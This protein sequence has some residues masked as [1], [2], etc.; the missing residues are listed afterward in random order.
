MKSFIINTGF[1]AALSLSVYAKATDTTATHSP[2]LESDTALQKLIDSARV[3]GLSLA[4]IKDGKI[5]GLKTLGVKNFQTKEKV[6]ATT[7]FEAAS[8]SK[9]VLAYITLKMI[10]RGQL[11]LGTKL[12]KILPHPRLVDTEKYQQITPLLIL[13]HQTGLPN[14]GDDP[15][16]FNFSPGEGFSYSGEGY[17]YL[18]KVLEH[19]S[20]KDLQA[21][22][23]EEVFVPLGMKNSHFTWPEE[24]ALDL[25]TGHDRTQNPVFRSVPEANGASSLHTTA[26]DYAKFMLAWFD[27]KNMP[28]PEQAFP[29]TWLVQMKGDEQGADTPLPEDGLVGWALG[30]GIQSSFQQYQQ[31]YTAWHW[32]DNGVFRA[33]VAINTH[34]Q[35]GIVYFTNSENGLAIAKRVVEPVVGNMNSTFHWLQYAQSDSQGWQQM[36]AGHEAQAKGDLATAIKYFAQVTQ[37]FPQNRR[38][39]NRIAWL[40]QS[41]ESKSKTIHLSSKEQMAITGQYGPRHI[42]LI[43]NNLYYQRQGNAKHQMHP[44]TPDLFAIGDIFDFR[45]EVIKD[46]QDKPIKLV[47]H[48]VNGFQDESPRTH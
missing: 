19:I 24:Q 36:Q 25:A 41:L 11:S 20:G 31:D 23:Q 28:T 18:Q 34:T 5:S 42:S 7:V 44:L 14:W 26:E 38:V 22:A 21:L 48:Y 43:D 13:S 17:V 1:W 47:G 33:F 9:P 27:R 37:Q 39:K 6:T 15:L 4:T 40:K 30:W 2:S 16:T 10:S 8:L 3:P 46:A 35:N 45:I 29:F 32:G 12:H